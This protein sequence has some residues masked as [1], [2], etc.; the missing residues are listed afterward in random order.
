MKQPLSF[1]ISSYSNTLDRTAEGKPVTDA[2]I[3]VLS[4][5]LPQGG[6]SGNNHGILE[7]QKGS[8]LIV[9]TG[10]DGQNEVSQVVSWHASFIDTASD[11]TKKLNVSGLFLSPPGSRQVLLT[12]WLTGALSVALDGLGSIK[13]S[14]HYLDTN[15][16]KDSDATYNITVSVDNQRLVVPEMTEFQPIDYIEPSRFTE[17]YG[18]C[19]ISG[20]IEGGLFNANI[21]LKRKEETKEKDIGG[22]GEA[23]LN[24]SGL[25]VKGEIKGGMTNN[26]YKKNFETTIRY[27]VFS[28]PC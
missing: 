6:S 18:D 21:H 26:E 17:V 7:N 4:P 22:G 2:D 1:G 25:D 23:S 14:G 19:F 12:R 3:K 28:L 9:G 5:E 20:F 15:A 8:K 13:V 10:I 11:A 16:L 27:P 24:V